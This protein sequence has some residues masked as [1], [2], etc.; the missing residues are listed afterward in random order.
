M[1]AINVSPGNAAPRFGGFVERQNLKLALFEIAGQR[2]SRFLYKVGNLGASGI[3][4][5]GDHFGF[6]IAIQIVRPIGTY[7]RQGE[8]NFGRKLA[9]RGLKTEAKWIGAVP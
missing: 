5:D 6:V 8:M 2:F 7:R 3:L 4:G 1:I 9:A